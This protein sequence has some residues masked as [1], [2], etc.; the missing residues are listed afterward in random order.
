VC[1]HLDAFHPAVLYAAVPNGGKRTKSEAVRLKKEGVRSGYPDLLIDE[2]RGPYHGLRVEMKRVHG[3]RPRQNQR[4]IH[5]RLAERGYRVVVGY[6][7]VDA[8][9]QIEAYLALPRTDLP[10]A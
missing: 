9:A 7:S 5:R 3:D 6:G 10:T 1:A 8:I 2:A 4:A